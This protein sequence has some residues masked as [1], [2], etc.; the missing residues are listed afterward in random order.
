MQ[1]VQ[2]RKRQRHS[3][4]HRRHCR[5]ALSL[6]RRRRHAAVHRKRDEP[7]AH[8]RQAEH[9][10]YVKDGVPQLLRPRQAGRRQPEAPGT[11]AAAHY[12]LTVDGGK[13]SDIRLRLSDIAPDKI[14]DPFKTFSR[15]RWRRAKAKPM[16]SIAPSHPKGS[17]EDEARV[18]RQ[19]LAGMLWTKQYFGLNVDEWLQEHGI[20]P[21]RQCRCDHPQSRVV[22]HG[23]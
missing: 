6:L 7:R 15:N 9:Q 19:A 22:P 13:R 23:E 5:R 21:P 16:S 2:R 12:R 8:L 14:G 10:S 17:T 18:M 3:A 4:A 20:D 11:K 1:Q